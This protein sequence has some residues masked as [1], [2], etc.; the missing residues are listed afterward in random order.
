MASSCK[1]RA[2]PN[3]EIKPGTICFSC[4]HLDRLV[5]DRQ[6]QMNVRN[7][8]DQK[9]SDTVPIRW[10]YNLP[11]NR[12]FTQTTAFIYTAH[13][14]SNWKISAHFAIQNDL[15]QP[16]TPCRFETNYNPNVSLNLCN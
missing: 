2:F 14:L 7:R 8:N 16:P 12:I 3:S 15:N 11:L 1:E 4:V 6:Y 13:E 10:M 9:V 5:T